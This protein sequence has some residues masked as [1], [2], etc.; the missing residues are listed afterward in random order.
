M[1]CRHPMWRFPERGT[2][3]TA[4]SRPPL[5]NRGSRC[6]ADYFGLDPFHDLVGFVL[7]DLDELVSR[8]PRSAEIS[9]VL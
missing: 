2:H 3:S 9:D 8:S 7:G 6:P 4:D 5:F 1:C